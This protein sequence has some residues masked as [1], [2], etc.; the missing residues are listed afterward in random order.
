M[1]IPFS[2]LTRQSAATTWFIRL[3]KGDNDDLTRRAFN[4]WLEQGYDNV[5]DYENC[6]LALE[7]ARE[8][9]GDPGLQPLIEE[10]RS[11]SRA[12]RA[13]EARYARSFLRR[14]GVRVPLLAASFAVV[15]LIGVMLAMAIGST[16]YETGIGEQRTIIAADDSVITLNTDSRLVVNYSRDV[17]RVRLERGQAFF[18]VSSDPQ[19]PFEVIAQDGIV[20]AVGTSFDVSIS[21]EYGQVKVTVLEGMIEVLPRAGERSSASQHTTPPRVSVGESVTYW[22]NGDEVQVTQ[23]DPGANKAWRDGKMDFD[24]QRLVDAIAEHNR[25]TSR[26]IVV[27][28]RELEDLRI[29]GVFR[30]GDTDAV[31]FLLRESLG[32]ITVQQENVIVLLPNRKLREADRTPTAVRANQG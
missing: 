8:L 25:Y 3:R 9:E 10:C 5:R 26:K 27:G 22:A 16:R 31:L 32:L 30:I 14:V 29:S 2:E 7:L 13:G 4:D 1:R 21:E 6:E 19:R 18:S 15:A 11:L 12:Y 23:A 28:A 20:R 17:R 24:N